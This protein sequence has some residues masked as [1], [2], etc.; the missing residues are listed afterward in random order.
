MRIHR[1]YCKSVSENNSVFQ[2][3]QSQSIHLI[4][5]LRL[6]EKDQVEVFDGCGTSAIC[7]IINPERNSVSLKRVSDLQV[8]KVSPKKLVFIVPFIKKDNFHFM[9][10]K[11]CE[12][13]IS[14]FIFY[15]PDLIDQSI[16][17]KDIS[18]IYSKVEEVIT[19]ACKQCGS[20]FIP[21]TNIAA[22]LRDALSLINNMDVCVFDINAEKSFNAADLTSPNVCMIT[23]PE[24]GFSKSEIEILNSNLFEF[25]LIGKNILRAETA[26]IV[27][28]SLIQNQFDKI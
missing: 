20:N 12:I 19:G 22:N 5:V 26:P 21:S 9:V 1:I 10:Q 4:K 28:A 2:I 23:G 16:V 25:R 7:E 6:K 15:K 24:S 14:E 13:G 8:A 18:K 27:I 11:L 3:D 17:K